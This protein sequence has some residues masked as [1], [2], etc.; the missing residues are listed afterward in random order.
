MESLG[1]S[2]EQKLIPRRAKVHTARH[3]SMN[4]CRP[5]WEKLPGYEVDSAGEAGSFCRGNWNSAGAIN[6]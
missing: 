1:D 5:V 2:G 4:A 6:N 3:K